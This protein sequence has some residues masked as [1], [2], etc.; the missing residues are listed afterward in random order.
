MVVGRPDRFPLT[1][2]TCSCQCQRRVFRLR[3]RKSFRDAFAALHR[4]PAL[5]SLTISF[6]PITHSF[7]NKGVPQS[8]YFLLQCD[9]LG[10]LGRNPNPLPTLHSLTI[11]KWLA[12][13]HELYTEAPFARIIASLRHLRFLVCIDKHEDAEWEEPFLMFWRQVEENVPSPA[14]NLECL[15]IDSDRTIGPYLNLNFNLL[16]YPRASQRSRS[17]TSSGRTVQLCA[18]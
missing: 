6:N 18:E 14:V 10:A 8:Q 5:G 9:V 17:G 15:T 1:L 3:E 13:P 16:A 2:Q 12:L 11:R 4:L 7:F